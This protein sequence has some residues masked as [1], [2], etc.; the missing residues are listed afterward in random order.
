MSAV[1]TLG[2]L[3]A[4]SSALNIAVGAGFVARRSGAAP[5]QAVLTGG[6]AA[7][8]MLTVFFAAVAAYTH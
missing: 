2:L 4:I 5:A 3:L 8:T 7:A 6:A 1:Q